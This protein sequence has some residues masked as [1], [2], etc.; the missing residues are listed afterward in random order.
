MVSE[1][2]WEEIV[3][4]LDDDTYRGVTA[5]SLTSSLGA[6]G[7]NA[8]QLAARLAPLFRDLKSV[9]AKQ[10]GLTLVGSWA[11]LVPEVRA[12]ALELSQDESQEA[13][14]TAATALAQLPNDLE[15]RT[16]LFAM[17]SDPAQNVRE[18]AIRALPGLA[19]AVTQGPDVPYL[20]V[21]PE[22]DRRSEV[23]GL[24]KELERAVNVLQD[25][26]LDDSHRK[27]VDDL[28]IPVISELRLI[29]ASAAEDLAA[30]QERRR[31]SI[32]RIG[33][34]TGAARAVALGAPLATSTIGNL[35]EAADNVIRVAD[36]L[37]PWG[38]ILFDLIKAPL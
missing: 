3:V 9:P 11:P 4:N 22:D 29:L 1:I 31:R 8:P 23:L 38:E 25:L 24:L 20:R 21:I 7:E 19:H 18:F 2:P 28:I 6:F 17:M 34:V 26:G 10:A 37:Q 16:R 30:V 27:V 15:A 5:E 14:Y 13:R 12:L 36:A 33:T 35:D 32:L